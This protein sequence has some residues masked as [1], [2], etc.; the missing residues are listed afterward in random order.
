MEMP[1]EAGSGHRLVQEFRSRQLIQA[2]G[3]SSEGVRVCLWGR[4]CSVDKATAAPIWG[5]RESC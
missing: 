4:V 1:L 2:G 5:L 3:R